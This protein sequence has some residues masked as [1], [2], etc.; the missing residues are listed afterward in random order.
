MSESSVKPFE[1]AWIA[2]S[3]SLASSLSW[4][5][6]MTSSFHNQYVAAENMKTVPSF[7]VANAV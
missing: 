3:P 6:A 1:L 7:A 4:L 5:F 2:Q